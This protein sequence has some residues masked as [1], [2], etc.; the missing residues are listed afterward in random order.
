M[1]CS[2]APMR[3]QVTPPAA[4]RGHKPGGYPCGRRRCRSHGARPD[5]ERTSNQV[6]PADEW[7][8]GVV[9]ATPGGPGGGFGGMGDF[10]VGAADEAAGDALR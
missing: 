10:R 2:A 5:P 3:A 4:E 1:I 9:W 6:A 7:E 8:P